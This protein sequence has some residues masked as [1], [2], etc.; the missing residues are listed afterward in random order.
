MYCQMKLSDHTVHIRVELLRK[1]NV[2]WRLQHLSCFGCFFCA[3]DI[4]KMEDVIDWY[5]SSIWQTSSLRRP[6]FLLLR[7]IERGTLVVCTYN[8]IAEHSSVSVMRVC[9]SECPGELT[10]GM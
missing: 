8:C 3:K 9:E 2:S 6:S 5:L 10:A 4:Q 1:N 7:G